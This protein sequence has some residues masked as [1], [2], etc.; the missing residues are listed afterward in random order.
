MTKLYRK[1]KELILYGIFGV[2]TTAVNYG[3][4]AALAHFAGLGV[5]LSNGI[6]WALSVLFAF[7]T[8]KLLVFESRSLRPG[9]VIRELCSFVACR[10][11]S[12]LLDMGIMVFF[13]GV[14]HA[15][16]LIVKLISNG[17]VI[18]INYVLSKAFVFSRKERVENG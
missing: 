15:N 9:R 18:L 12:G 1:Y 8:N 11:A 4:Y 3:S 13:T 16:D 6:A 7:V 10:L 14:A 5:A 17:V 2:L